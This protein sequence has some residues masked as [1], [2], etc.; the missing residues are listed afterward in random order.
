MKRLVLTHN[1]EAIVRK[2]KELQLLKQEVHKKPNIKVLEDMSLD[3]EMNTVLVVES[4][5]LLMRNCLITLRP[6]PSNL[7]R[8]VPAILALPGS[9][10]TFVNCDFIGNSSNVTT[11][12]VLLHC[13]TVMISLC[14]FYRFRGGAVY[15]ISHGK[16]Q[17][18]DFPGAEMLI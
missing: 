12:M 3:P 10:V 2:F 8:Q 11:G 5:S 17:R 7:T 9:H 15:T 6:L 13:V 18:L 16:D 1:G 4:G 14:R